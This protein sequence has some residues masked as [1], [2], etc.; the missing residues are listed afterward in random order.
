[1]AFIMDRKY[2]LALPLYRQ[3]Q[4][5][6]HYGIDLSRQTLANWMLRG[7]ND[8][9]SSLYNCMHAILIQHDILH[10]DETTFTSSS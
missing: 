1:M 6:K 8:W 7:A 9:L 10:A 2:S 3:E 4:Q 5:F